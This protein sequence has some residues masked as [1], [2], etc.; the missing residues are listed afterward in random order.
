[1]GGVS[2]A[3]SSS[4]GA[5]GEQVVEEG[6]GTEGHKWAVVNGVETEQLSGEEGF[7]LMTLY[8]QVKLGYV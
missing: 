8:P 2:F 3:K 5:V 1:M 6:A 7:T 4:W